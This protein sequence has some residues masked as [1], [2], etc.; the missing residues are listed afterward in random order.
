[1]SRVIPT[2]L[3]EHLNGPVT[4][5]CRLLKITLKNGDSY[6]L[7][8]LDRHIT[9]D[10]T[11]YSAIDGFDTSVIAT[12]SGLSVDNAEAYALLSGDIP[13]ITLEM[14]EAGQLDDAQWSLLLVNWNDLSMGHVILDAGDVG[15]VRTV[16]QTVYMPELLS[17]AMRLRQPIGHVWSRTCRAI[18]GTPA[19]SQTGCGVDTDPL[20]VSGEVTGLGDETKRV[21]ADSSLDIDPAPVP[22]R[23]EWLTGNNTSTSRMYQVEAYSNTSG[24]IA[25][26]EPTAFEIQVGDTFRIRPDCPKTPEACKGY[27]NWVNYKGEPLIPVGDGASIMSPGGSIPGGMGGSTIVD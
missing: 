12:D 25:L 18:F 2:A 23:V 20:W 22:G 27:D 5:T 7:T 16:D 13:G 10:G 19:D 9:Y 4:T 17:Y 11:D 8:T 14:V 15:E 21:F 26:L 24:T 1:M 3:Q 6:G